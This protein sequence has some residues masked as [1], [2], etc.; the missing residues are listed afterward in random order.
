MHITEVEADEEEE[1]I[2]VLELME[3]DEVLRKIRT[4]NKGLKDMRSELRKTRKEFNVL[5]D[6]LRKTRREHVNKALKDFRENHRK[7]FRTVQETLVKKAEEV[8]D[9]EKE[10]YIEMTS[11]SVYE[12]L[13]WR[14]YHEAERSGSQ[15][16]LT[17]G[18]TR[19]TDPWNS[20]FWYA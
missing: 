17:V 10:I 8:Y 15:F 4:Q 5:R 12:F 20:A 13:P 18:N 6:K 19:H 11:E 9:K 2:D 7:E 16:K 1:E 14:E 3:S